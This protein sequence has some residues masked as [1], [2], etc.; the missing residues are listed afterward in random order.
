MKMKCTGAV[1]PTD[2][3][4]KPHFTKGKI[5]DAVK[6]GGDAVI[7]G[8]EKRRN[9]SFEWQAVTMHPKGWVILGVAKFEEVAE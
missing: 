1:S 2:K 7:T 4:Q 3:K 6:V 8:D 9:G 5:Y